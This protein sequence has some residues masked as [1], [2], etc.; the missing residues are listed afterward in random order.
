MTIA[1]T[2][3][4]ALAALM[5]AATIGLL[6]QPAAAQEKVWKHALLNAKADAGSS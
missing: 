4:I 1:R 3:F 5:A 2:R 6:S